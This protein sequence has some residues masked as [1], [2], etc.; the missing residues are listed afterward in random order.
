MLERIGRM[1][2]QAREA[3]GL[4]LTDIQMETNIRLTYLR[5][6]EA[7]AG[8][9]AFP[10][11]P[12]HRGFMKTYARAVGLSPEEVLKLYDEH[13]QPTE[14][15]TEGGEAESEKA[16]APVAAPPAATPAAAQVPKQGDRG[17]NGAQIRGP[18]PSRPRGGR[19][20]GTGRG[21]AWTVI[22]IVVLL[23]AV[24]GGVWWF[25]NRG[26]V[27]AKTGGGGGPVVTNPGNT[28]GTSGTGGGGTGGGATPPPDTTKPPEPPAVTVTRKDVDAEN[29][30]VTVK[31]ADRL[32]VTVK[33]TERCWFGVTQDGAV[34][35]EETLDP[36][37]S[38]T[39]T[40]SGKLVLR[41]GN[42]DGATFSVN[43]QDQG[44]MGKARIPRNIRVEKAP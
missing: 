6:L 23:L 7:G 14:G 3:K 27:S 20:P 30:L 38:R 15:S 12:Y 28:G 39:W 13:Y 32:S 31:G 42:P 1:L 25:S 43:G 17:L 4:S 18:E 34:I 41:V 26:A 44:S 16:A 35:A 33:I 37:D 8:H 11:D 9:D 36:G 19:S 40:A 29:T 24:S 2:R 5:A 21:R 10:G 22:A